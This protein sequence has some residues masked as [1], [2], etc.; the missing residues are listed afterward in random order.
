MS[1]ENTAIVVYRTITLS[2]TRVR[3]GL[4]ELVYHRYRLK[5]ASA[6]DAHTLTAFC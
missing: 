6:I 5:I 2:H 3:V 4:F 1:E